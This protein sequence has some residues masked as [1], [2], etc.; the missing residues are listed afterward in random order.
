MRD[1]SYMPKEKTTWYGLQQN[2][3]VVSAI[4]VR[5]AMTRFGDSKFGFLWV[6]GEPAA[7]IAIFVLAHTY[8]PNHIPFGDSAA[9]FVLTGVF[10]FRMTRGISKK[11]ECGIINNIPL[12]T[13]P[14]VKPIDGIVGAF[15]FESIVWLVI[16]GIFLTGLAVTMDRPLIV[17]PDQFVECLMAILYF[18]F[19]FAMFNATVGAL[20][21]RYTTALGM[22]NLPLMMFSGIFYMPVMMP[23]EMQSLLYW[24]PFVHCVEWFRVSTYLDYIPLLDKSYLFSVS[25]GLLTVSLI[26]ERFYRRQILDG[27]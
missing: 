21:P 18:A 17:Y 20:I 6:V 11:A 1:T 15:V 22:I 9:L 25:T 27:R 12:L 13:Y 5:I 10:G 2:A 24:N 8:I 7:F 16:C 26:A 23:P 19:S 4:I 14:Q 3:I